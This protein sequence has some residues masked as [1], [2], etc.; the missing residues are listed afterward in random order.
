MVLIHRTAVYGPVRTVVWEGEAARPTPIP[1][2]SGRS[3]SVEVEVLYPA[4]CGEGLAVP[5]D[6]AA[7]LLHAS[8]RRNISTTPLRFG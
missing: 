7:Q 2:V 5:V 6:R 8:F 4:D 1:I 3:D